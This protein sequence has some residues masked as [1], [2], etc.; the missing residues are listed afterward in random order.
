MFCKSIEHFKYIKSEAVFYKNYYK[1]EQ[2][3]K[4]VCKIL[5]DIKKILNV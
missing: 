2:I 3:W 1:F 4:I 5:K